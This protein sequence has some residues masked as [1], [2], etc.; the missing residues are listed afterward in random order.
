MFSVHK[1]KR[2]SRIKY[3]KNYAP[4]PCFVANHSMHTVHSDYFSVD[5]TLLW[6][7]DSESFGVLSLLKLGFGIWSSVKA[8]F[9]ER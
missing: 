8:A 6:W 5:S 4:F 1:M 7:M 2:R 9:A 3:Y